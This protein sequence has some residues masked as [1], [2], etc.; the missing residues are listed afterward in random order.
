MTPAVFAAIWPHTAVALAAL[1]LWGIVE[2]WT[3]SRRRP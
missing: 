2:L 3:L 1:G